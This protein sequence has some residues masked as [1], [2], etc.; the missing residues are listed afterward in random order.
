MI[1]TVLWDVDGTLLDFLASEK[2]SVRKC[3]EHFSFGDCTEEKLRLYSEINRSW[4]EKL[5]RNECTKY[6]TLSYRFRDFFREIGVDFTDYDALNVYYQKQL[7]ENA[8]FFP[9][10]R[11]CLLA[12]KGRYLQAAVTNGTRPVQKRKLELTG[13]DRVFDAVFISDEIGFEKPN[14]EF[15]DAVFRALPD[16]RRE[17]TIIIG[18]SLSSDIK[19]GKAA[20]IRTCHFC[21]GKIPEKENAD[22]VVQTFEEIPPLIQRI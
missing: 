17:E 1:Q 2:V 6:E 7:G 21:P 4:W 18:D 16:S 20:G 22:F 15:F 10:A 11:E 3:F 14:P 19:G 12:L 13:L 8:S 9:G 5:E